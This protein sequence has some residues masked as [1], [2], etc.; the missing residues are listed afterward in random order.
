MYFPVYVR[1][2]DSMLK[3]L[4]FIP[5]TVIIERKIYIKKNIQLGMLYWGS[6]VAASKIV[7]HFKKPH[8]M[9]GLLNR[10]E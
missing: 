4:C 8:P 9:H 2:T 10:I 6:T 1:N 7:S 3:K 5:T